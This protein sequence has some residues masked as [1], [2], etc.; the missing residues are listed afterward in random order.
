MSAAEP[1]ERIGVICDAIEEPVSRDL[2]AKAAQ[3]ARRAEYQHP[4]NRSPSVTAA[5][6]VY[7][8][9][10]L[11]HEKLTQQTVADAAEVNVQSIRDGYREL[12]EHED[13]AAGVELRDGRGDGEEPAGAAG[14]FHTPPALR[15]VGFALLTAAGVGVVSAH[16]MQDLGVLA[17]AEPTPLSEL[18]PTVGAIVLL[19]VLVALVVPLLPQSGPGG[20]RL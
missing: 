4:M 10:L 6:A 11:V 17:L 20:G 16:V 14:G 12:F 13:I 7:L 1:V 2:R 5:S 18:W 3:L 15:I 19:T 8:A 9:G